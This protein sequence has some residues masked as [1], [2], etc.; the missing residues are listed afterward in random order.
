[1]MSDQ[2]QQVVT[3]TD[4]QNNVTYIQFVPQ[5][6]I[7]FCK[8]EN[9]DEYCYEETELPEEEA[10]CEEA[11]DEESYI[12]ED[13]IGEVEVE[14]LESIVVEPKKNQTKTSEHH[15]TKK[16]VQVKGEFCLLLTGCLRCYPNCF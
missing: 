4:A 2:Y 9:Q 15:V 8:E 6:Q 7:L 13:P 12:E 3:T 11:L 1:M 5:S 10:S 14:V 16:L